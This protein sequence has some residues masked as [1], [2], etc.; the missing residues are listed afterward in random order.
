[1]TYSNDLFYETVL[2]F[3]SLPAGLYVGPTII[4]TLY[5][6]LMVSFY[7]EEPLGR[8]EKNL[9]LRRQNTIRQGNFDNLF[10]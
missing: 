8:T 9:L 10:M 6:H 5:M 4:N 3:R 1:M 7:Q 2:H